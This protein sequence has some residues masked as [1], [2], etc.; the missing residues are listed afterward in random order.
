M[1]YYCFPATDGLTEFE[2][3][4]KFITHHQ[5]VFKPLIERCLS[6]QPEQRGTFEDVQK[7]LSVHQPR[8][9][10]KQAKNLD[11]EMV[12]HELANL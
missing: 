11:D 7:Y 9:G 12:R 8:Y 3:H 6:E 5:N 2:K 10:G 4:T 1:L